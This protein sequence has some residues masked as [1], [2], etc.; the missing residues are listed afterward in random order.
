MSW[1]M[2]MTCFKEGE[3]ATFSCEIAE[4]AFKPYIMERQGNDWVLNFPD[5]GSGQV[6]VG[7]DEANRNLVNS[8]GFNRPSSSPY[9]WNA[10]I[11]ILRQ[12]DTV[13][14]WAGEGAVV[15]RESTIAN[16]PESFIEA[17]G[18]PT[19]TTDI[20]EIHRMIEKA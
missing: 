5:D 20:Q 10:L 9:F 8:L 11:D 17:I 4:A 3:V 15:A 14:Y 2:W 19:V 7:Y 6:S 16:L 13:L 18:T 12:T 1:D